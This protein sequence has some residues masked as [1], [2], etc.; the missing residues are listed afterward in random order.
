MPYSGNSWQQL[1]AVALQ[2]QSPTV[3]CNPRDQTPLVPEISS[4]LSLIAFAGYLPATDRTVS[5]RFGRYGREQPHD[6]WSGQYSRAPENSARGMPT[7][8]EENARLRAMLGINHS[9]PNEP[10]SQALPVPKPRHLAKA[11]FPRQKRRSRSFEIYSVGA[12]MFSPFDGKERAANLAIHLPAS[13]T[14]A[15][16]ISETR[17]AKEGCPQNPDAPATDG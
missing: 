1:T 8:S 6:A 11:V 16:S 17:R 13:W 7:A 10:V 9:P 12:K 5:D 4:G 2:V 14:G 3:V 15:P